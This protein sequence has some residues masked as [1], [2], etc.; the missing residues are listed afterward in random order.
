[1]WP[2]Y[3]LFKSIL[4]KLLLC[5]ILYIIMLTWY[6]KKKK[7]RMTSNLSEEE[8]KCPYAHEWSRN[9]SKEEK[10]RKRQYGRKQYKNHLEN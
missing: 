2:I 7:Q 4:Y 3:D 6:Y 9:L 1:M 8:K 10:N 5:K